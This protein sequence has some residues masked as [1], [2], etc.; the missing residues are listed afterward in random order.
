MAEANGNSSDYTSFYNSS[1][2][3]RII[4]ATLM[5]ALAIASLCGNGIVAFLV[6]FQQRLR[7]LSNILLANLACIDLVKSGILI[8]LLTAT[9]VTHPSDSPLKGQVACLIL[10]SFSA[11]T[12]TVTVLAYVTICIDRYIAVVHPVAYK[13]S[14]KSKTSIRS[15]FVLSPWFIAAIVVFPIYIG[16][17]IDVNLGEETC[18]RYRAQFL[19][20]TTT[21]AV[22]LSIFIVSL[23][24]LIVLYALLFNSVRELAK[25]RIQFV[26]AANS[27][28]VEERV[29][30]LE[31]HTAKTTA[32]TVAAYVFLWII[33]MVVTLLRYQDYIS[34]WLDFLSLFFQYTS[35]V[36]N[37][38][39]YFA[40]IKE[41]RE[42]LKR[43]IRPRDW[44]YTR[45]TSVTERSRRASTGVNLRSP[46]ASK[47]D[48]ASV[49]G[50][51]TGSKEDGPVSV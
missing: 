5:I 32:I 28:R 25:R 42:G 39:L 44:R 29:R 35:G 19:A 21:T 49:A 7:S 10:L 31:I 20:N 27:H 2:E 9:I 23:F 43:V 14:W 41:L 26:S 46:I 22:S 11:F 34:F 38:F 33:Y 3:E 17:H 24:A 8:P 48:E 30:K 6:I 40:R 1:K 16:S 18:T 15:L 36:I 12:G 13:Q 37:P 4:Q 45:S 51:G 50:S 47:Y